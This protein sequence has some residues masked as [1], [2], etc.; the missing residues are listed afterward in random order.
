MI[1]NRYRSL[2]KKLKINE[3]SKNIQQICLSIIEKAG[4]RPVKKLGQ[5]T[6]SPEQ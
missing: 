4:I 6:S 1:K 5:W 3:K 2:I